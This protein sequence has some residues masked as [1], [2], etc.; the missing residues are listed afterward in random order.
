MYRRHSKMAKYAVDYSRFENLADSDEDEAPVKKDLTTKKLQEL[1]RKDPQ[2]LDQMEAEVKATRIRL[3]EAKKLREAASKPGGEKAAASIQDNIRNRRKEMK[4]DMKKMQDEQRAIEEQMRQLDQLQSCGDEKSLLEFFQRQGL[5]EDQ[6][7]RG[8]GGDASGL[9]DDMTEKHRQENAAADQRTQDVC[10]VADQLS[11]VL[12]G[13]QVAVEAPVEPPKPPSPQKPKPPLVMQPDCAQQR[14]DESLVVTVTL[15]GCSSRDAKLD[16]SETHLR[17]YAPAPSE[18]GRTREYRLNAPLSRSVRS[19][20]AR[21][22]WSKKLSA[23]V[24]TIP[25]VGSGGKE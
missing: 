12:K 21:A 8:L 7:R 9:V 24:V 22:K 2:A 18:H 4:N 16:V 14:R 15:P 25:V 5:S 1:H 3:E 10:D 11:R 17:L 6:L 13:D 23:L 20:E 19:E